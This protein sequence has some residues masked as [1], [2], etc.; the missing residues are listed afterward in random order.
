MNSNKVFITI[1]LISMMVYFNYSNAQDSTTYYPKG[2]P[3]ILNIEFN[4]FLWL[5]AIGGSFGSEKVSE[6][7]DVPAA[8]LLSNLRFAFMFNADVSKGKF[9]ASPTYIYCKLGS[10]EVK[11]TDK[12][13]DPAVVSYPGFA[14]N[15]F[16]LIAGMRLVLDK[17]FIMD[18]YL[19]FRYTNYSVSGWVEGVLDTTDFSEDANYWDPVLGL[20]MHYFPHP[21]V[22]LT[23]KTDVGGF[24]AGSNFSWTTSLQGG[25]SVSP[26]VDLL[27]GFMAYGSDFT[28]D[29]ELG[30]QVGLK[31][32]MYGFNLGARIM[33]P[34][35]Y[36]DPAIFKKKAK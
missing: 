25:Y 13:G 16:E 14:M 33:I 1:M 20:R 34:A 21:R 22:P 36:K 3:E 23:L 24:G 19:G 5:P 9:F 32:N 30:N 31:L 11:K 4:P 12:N 15:I 18:P 35:R 8:E 10:E 7:I 29:N 2:D 27:V 28:E 26:T 17:K 6:D